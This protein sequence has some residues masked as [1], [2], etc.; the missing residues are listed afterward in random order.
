MATLA[1]RTLCRGAAVGKRS[2][3]GYSARVV[4]FARA[5]RVLVALACALLCWWCGPTYVWAT[6]S[7][8]ATLSFP[9]RAQHAAQHNPSGRH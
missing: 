6:L 9:D 8:R 2:G 5:Y 7:L 3:A 4:T 1:R